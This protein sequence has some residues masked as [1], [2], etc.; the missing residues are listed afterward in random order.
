MNTSQGKPRW[1]LTCKR[2]VRAGC[3]AHFEGRSGWVKRTL[4]KRDPSGNDRHYQQPE[5]TSADAAYN[6]GHGAPCFPRAANSRHD[7]AKGIE[8]LC[9]HRYA[10]VLH[11]AIYVANWAA[12]TMVGIFNVQSKTNALFPP[13]S[14]WQRVLLSRPQRRS[15]TRQ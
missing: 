3:A 9:Q 12:K 11:Q 15:T 5:H 13:V 6:P 8:F 4:I 14:V 1:R 2:L 10:G 7:L